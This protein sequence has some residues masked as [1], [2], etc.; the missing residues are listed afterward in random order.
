[1]TGTYLVCSCHIKRVVGSHMTGI[2]QIYKSSLIFQVYGTYLVCTRYIVLGSDHAVF[3][4]SHKP[5]L[6]LV[7]TCFRPGQFK[8]SADRD[9]AAHTCWI[10]REFIV[11]S[12][13]WRPQWAPAGSV[14]GSVG[15]RRVARSSP[16]PGGRGCGGRGRGDPAATADSSPRP[17]WRL[18]AA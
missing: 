6:N 5:G 10:A 3:I 8:L 11:H 17:C 14:G 16:L 4:L 2:Y 15:S 13:T 9:A 7:Y 12:S 1:M 18:A